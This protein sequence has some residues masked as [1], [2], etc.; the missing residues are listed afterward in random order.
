MGSVIG[1]AAGHVRERGL[2][3]LGPTVHRQGLHHPRR[4]A[5]GQR[6]HLHPAAADRR[7]LAL[8]LKL[9]WHAADW[10]VRLRPAKGH[11]V[12]L[13]QRDGETGVENQNQTE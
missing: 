13:P 9:H 1:G 7:P 4:A 5:A 2:D 10:S 6:D 3:P 11:A 12:E 8:D